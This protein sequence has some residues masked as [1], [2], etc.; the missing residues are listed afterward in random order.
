MSHQVWEIMARHFY[1]QTYPIYPTTT[2]SYKHTLSIHNTTLEQASS[3]YHIELH[4]ILVHINAQSLITPTQ[5]PNTNKHIHF[6][7]FPP[8]H[9]GS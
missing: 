2:Y 7:H 4:H 9:T 8:M 1:K 3:Y 5:H 6:I